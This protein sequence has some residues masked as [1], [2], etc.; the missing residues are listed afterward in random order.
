MKNI[1]YLRKFMK[2]ICIDLD[3]K[4]PVLEISSDF[5]TPTTLA[6]YDS[7]FDKIKIRKSY[8]VPFDL[9]FSVAHELR[10]KYQIMY[11]T[12]DLSYYTSS[13]KISKREYNL[14]SAEIDANA[15]AYLIMKATFNVECFFNGLD[16]DIIE[17]IKDKAMQIANNP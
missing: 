5:P 11:N 13:N 1:K 8:E 4:M 12:C 7:K 16:K 9:F 14:Q 2:S 15:Y 17:T 3:I 6:L 10:H